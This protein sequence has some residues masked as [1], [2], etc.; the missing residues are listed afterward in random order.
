MFLLQLV[1][2]R[3]LPCRPESMKLRDPKGGEPRKSRTLPGENRQMSAQ[4]QPETGSPLVI[5]RL[6]GSTRSSSRS[7]A[8]TSEPV[9]SPRGQ[10]A[11]PPQSSQ[12]DRG[13][14]CREL[15]LRRGVGRWG[16]HA[17]TFLRL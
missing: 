3:A 7:L 9:R 15:E 14:R 12:T 1:T 2:G 10:A 4:L 5:T 8:P 6:S 17:Q 16:L 11:H 13:Q